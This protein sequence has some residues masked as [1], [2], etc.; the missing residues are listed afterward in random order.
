MLS[1]VPSALAFVLTPADLT[2]AGLRG[3][4]RRWDTPASSTSASGMGGGLSYIIEDGLCE[5][6]LP[7]FPEALFVDCHAIH[8][9]IRRAMNVW[10]SN[11]PSLVA[12][13]NVTSSTA[14]CAPP[15]SIDLNTTA[16]P[17][18]LY[19]GTAD[20][21][22]YPSL[23]AYV[24]N[25]GTR[26]TT[27]NPNAPWYNEPVRSPN[28]MVFTGIEIIKRSELRIQTHVCFFLDQTFC[29]G[30]QH[31]GAAGTLWIPL[32]CFLC[33]GLALL[34]VLGLAIRLIYATL[35]NS[36]KVQPIEQG[37]H[38]HPHPS[39]PGLHAHTKCSTVLDHLTH[40]SPLLTL[41][42]LFLLIFPLVFYAQI[43]I[44]CTS[45]FSFEGSIAHE[46]GHVLGFDHPDEYPGANIDGCSVTPSNCMDPFSGSSTTGSSC[47]ANAPVESDSIM[48]SL[49][50]QASSTCLTPSD[51]NGLHMLYPTCDAHLEPTEVQCLQ[52]RRLS[53]WLRLAWAVGW[54][55]L[56]STALLVIPLTL[57][58]RR[59]R[60][61][62][63]ELL[64]QLGEAEEAADAATRQA[65]VRRLQL[66]LHRAGFAGG[67]RGGGGGA[68]TTTVPPPPPATT[69][70]TSATTTT[71]TAPANK[72][73]PDVSFLDNQVTTITRVDSI[74]NV[75]T[76]TESAAAA[77]PVQSGGGM[78]EDLEE[79]DLEEDSFE[80]FEALARGAGR[81]LPRADMEPRAGS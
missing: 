27:N 64:K 45:C 74:G 30:F 39:P 12:F 11:H 49:S 46:I 42:V 25:Y 3:A 73:Y 10:H 78:V 40:V 32:I 20:G 54:P 17:W 79:E 51:R 59:E 76:S 38:H 26:A 6:L 14:A 19:I 8:D 60:K 71:T 43:Y 56:L 47:I 15:T 9:S 44:P 48:L 24:L 67:G 18:E 77:Q 75:T 57:L 61:R 2:H 1:F 53:G 35:R 68:A 58:R 34:A 52:T 55:F 16:C 70:V 62:L 81:Q 65:N 33:F 80:Q 31:L 69:V 7:L 22:T 63:D 4:S 72:L 5:T 29:H 37:D 41:L 13:R 66:M 21:A 36:A 23:A 28:N 50:R